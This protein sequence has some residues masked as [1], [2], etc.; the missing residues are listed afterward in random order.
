[1]PNEQ[2]P[3][4]LSG[5]GCEVGQ[6]AVQGSHGRALKLDM[7]KLRRKRRCHP[8]SGWPGGIQAVAIDQAATVG[9]LL[10]DG[11]LCTVRDLS[12]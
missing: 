11:T 12:M 3:N 5:S 6:R 7:G 8:S 9:T 1:M 2:L 10:R 4:E